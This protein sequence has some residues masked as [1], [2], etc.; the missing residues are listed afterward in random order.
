MMMMNLRRINSV[1][2]KQSIKRM[3]NVRVMIVNHQSNQF[4]K[5]SI[6]S[7]KRYASKHKYD[8][9]FNPNI[10][11]RRPISARN[12]ILLVYIGGACLIVYV[13]LDIFFKEKVPVIGRKRLLLLPLSYEKE[14]GLQQFKQIKQSSKVLL[15]NHEYSQIIQS[16]GNRIKSVAGTDL[17]FKWEFIVVDEP[18][19][20][21]FCLPAGKVVFYK[22]LMDSL[23]APH[24]E[25]HEAPDM[26]EKESLVAGVMAHE[27]SH[28]L[29]RHHAE[30]ISLQ[31][32][33]GIALT[34][35]Q[36]IIGGPLPGDQ[37]LMNVGVL[38]PFSRKHEYEADLIG[39]YLMSRAC[40]DPKYAIKT[41]EKMQKMQ[42][43]DPG[44]LQY[45]STH[46]SFGNRLDV[47]RE[48][49][50]NAER[51]RSKYCGLYKSTA[52]S[53][54]IKYW[55]EGLNIHD[56]SKQEEKSEWGDQ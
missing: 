20:N 33:M 7:M 27:I 36:A 31:A 8:P 13:L 18:V 10:R 29:L 43:V 2:N 32:K 41:F 40:Y 26:K 52:G 42:S 1:I 17:G 16:V 37:L 3:N 9:Q 4:R 54:K 23:F 30:Q 15:P 21:A 47:F 5:F 34:I 39:L 45:V 55:W 44:V 6:D 49:L 19:L 56:L 35:V 51:E 14:M 24:P 53:K 25:T 50:N 38:L 46:P 12:P 11:A 48:H 28:A 22:G